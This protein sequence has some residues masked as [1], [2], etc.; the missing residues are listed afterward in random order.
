MGDS[1]CLLW[2]PLCWVV[3]GALHVLLVAA[4]TLLG[5]MLTGQVFGKLFQVWL[6]PFGCTEVIL[7]CSL[8]FPSVTP[9]RKGNFNQCAR[10][11]GTIEYSSPS[12]NKGTSEGSIRAVIDFLKHYFS[13]RIQTHSLSNQQSVE[14]NIS[15]MLQQLF[16]DNLASMA[17]PLLP[18]LPIGWCGENGSIVDR[19]KGIALI[20]TAHHTAFP[21]RMKVF[22]Y[23]GG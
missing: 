4:F 17:L 15:S 10:Y 14:F 23:I 20:W 2:F 6:A 11:K 7:T 13:L 21:L 22:I 8:F 3:L 18:S 9:S 12:T 1:R 5:H 19:G 16:T